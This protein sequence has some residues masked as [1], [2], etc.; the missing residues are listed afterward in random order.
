MR[1]I[2]VDVT[3]GLVYEG[4]NNRGIGVLPTPMLFVATEFDSEGSRPRIHSRS[5][6]PDASRNKVG[7]LS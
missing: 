7:R 4:D 1:A 6:W 5:H 2:G 3:E